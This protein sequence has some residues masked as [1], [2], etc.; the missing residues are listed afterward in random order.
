MNRIKMFAAISTALVSFFSCAFAVAQTTPPITVT[1]WGMHHGGWV[2]YK[3]Q[4]K[5]LGT[6]PIDNFFIGYYPPSSTADGDTELSV[7]P[8]YPGGKSLWLPSS[9]SQSPSGWGVFL[10][11]PEESATFALRWVEAAW[12]RKHQ[13]GDQYSDVPIAQ[14]PP[15]VM[16]AG[17][18][19]DQFS[20][21][22]PKPEYS[23]VQ[24]HA[25]LFYGHNEI[26]VQME[27]GDSIAPTLKLEIEK[28]RREDRFSTLHIE[29]EA[30]D[31][32]DPQ[33]DVTLEAITANQPIYPGE[34][35]AGIGTN[36]RQ[37]KLR[38]VP[39]RIYQISYAAIDASG[40][41]TVKTISYRTD[42][43]EDRDK[44]RKRD[45]ERDKEKPSDRH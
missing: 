43:E 9:V 44:D 3:Y 16:P 26:T 21:T 35:K 13:P 23:Y 25:N 5:N 7:V 14:N 20:V 11:Y 42:S 45:N 28:V 4:V 8:Y 34:V 39:G 27:K 10:S 33:P 17:A 12:Y 22:L 15:N 24:G 37:I 1:A 2:V 36:E 19:W 29:A 41:K 6:L 30:K 32:Y 31:N 40:N 18:T 38:N